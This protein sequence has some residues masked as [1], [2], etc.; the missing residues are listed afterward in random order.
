MTSIYN[1]L[2]Y[3]THAQIFFVF[4]EFGILIRFEL[5]TLNARIRY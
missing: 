5:N 1:I 3:R 2:K 4:I